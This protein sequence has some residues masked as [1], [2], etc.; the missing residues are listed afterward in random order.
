MLHELAVVCFDKIS[1]TRAQRV[2]KQAPLVDSVGDLMPN[3]RDIFKSWFDF[4]SEEVELLDAE[5]E[6]TGVVERRILDGGFSKF[7]KDTTVNAQL[8]PRKL[9][10]QMGAFNG[11][12]LTHDYV[13]EHDFMSFYT[14]KAA[15]RPGVVRSNLH[16]HQIGSDLKPLTIP[17]A[18]DPH[19]C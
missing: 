13:S 11:G 12:N 18:N 1:A 16:A 10:E 4:Y 8:D 5:G 3:A 19:Q 2:I 14:V 6:K 15:E 7:L 17:D 9:K